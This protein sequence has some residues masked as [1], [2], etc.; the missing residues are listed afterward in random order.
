MH[1]LEITVEDIVD[2]LAKLKSPGLGFATSKSL[3]PI[4]VDNDNSTSS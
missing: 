3:S 4:G 2:K 1:E